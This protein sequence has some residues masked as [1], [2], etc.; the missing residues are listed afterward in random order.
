ME[1]LVEKSRNLLAAC[2][3]GMSADQWYECHIYMLAFAFWSLSW[4]IWCNYDHAHVEQ[5]QMQRWLFN[6]P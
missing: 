2:R 5:G 4:H 3:C 1:R 6:S